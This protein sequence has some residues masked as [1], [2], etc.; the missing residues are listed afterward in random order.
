MSNSSIN[1]VNLDFNTLKSSLRTYLS[2]QD[3]F[4]DYN[5]DGSAMSVLLDVLSY[6]T[7][8]NAFYL[9]MIGAEGFLDSAQMRGSIFSHAKELNY[10]PRSVRSSVANVTISFT[11]SGVNQPYV[12]RKGETFSTIVK[13][14]SYV[15]SVSSDQILSSANSTYTATFDIHEGSYITDSYIMGDGDISQS[16]PISNLGVDTDSISV[17]VYEHSASTPRTYSKATSLLGLNSQSKVYFVQPSSTGKYE[18]VFG[19]DIMGKRPSAGSTIVLDYRVTA[20]SDANGAKDFIINFDPTGL[21]ELTSSVSV[22]TNLY[23][24]DTVGAYSVNGA[25]AESIESVRYYAPRHFQTQERAITTNDYETILKMQYPEIGAISVYGGED[26][27]PPRYGKV[28]VAVDIKNVDGLPESKKREY[29]NFLKSRMPLS[30]DPIFIQPQF[31]Y[32]QVN[33]KV[34]YNIN[35]TTRTPSNLNSSITLAITEFATKYL[36][37]FRA[38]LYYSKLT[39][40]IDAVDDSIVSNQTDLFVYKRLNPAL[41]RPQN[42]V[43]DFNIPLKKTYYV[44]DKVSSGRQLTQGDIESAHSVH[45]SLIIYNGT[46]CELE[47]NGAGIVRLVKKQQNEHVVIKNVGTVDY[48]TGRILLNNFSLDSYEGNYF[49]IFVTPRNKDI[50]INKNEILYIESSD[51]NLNIEAVRN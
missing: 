11:A 27:V 33:S 49:K 18:I 2:S 12:I 3:Q 10:L 41:D 38:A 30:I 24:P 23:S 32:V 40:E 46:K 17:L 22:V 5:F 6:N 7:Y 21:G 19:D 29:Y 8:K 26:A 36:N 39:S 42:L 28:F 31:T 50:V 51:I 34:K 37:N 20:G 4:K 16:F 1:L 14:N 25:E 35:N 43:I 47:D 45:S 48:D 15:F 9:N 13:Q 44:L